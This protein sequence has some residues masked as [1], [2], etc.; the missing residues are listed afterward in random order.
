MLTANDK[1]AKEICMEVYR[2]EIRLE[3]V[4]EIK[5]LGYVLGVA[6]TH[7]AEYS[8]NVARGRRVVGAIRSLVNARD[9]AA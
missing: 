2:E 4:S 7:G 3:H 1:E 8:R 5:Y 9:F 6:G